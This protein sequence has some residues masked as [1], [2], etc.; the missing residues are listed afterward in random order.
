MTTLQTPD[1][2]IST[3]KLEGGY[4]E[5]YVFFGGINILPPR[6]PAVLML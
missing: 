5:K 2:F 1:V 4:V 6:S 3:Q